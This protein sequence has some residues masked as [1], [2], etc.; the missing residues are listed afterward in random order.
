MEPKQA[1]NGAPFVERS[2][3]MIK[4]RYL[5][6]LGALTAA[7]TACGADMQGPAQKQEPRKR[8]QESGKIPN[9]AHHHR[10]AASVELRQDEKING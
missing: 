8:E 7:I 6:A 10:M 9:T 1:S 5:V 4:K 3:T 2:A